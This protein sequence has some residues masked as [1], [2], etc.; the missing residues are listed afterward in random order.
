MQIDIKVEVP[1]CGSGEQF[2]QAE[3]FKSTSRGHSHVKNISPL[4]QLE[5]GRDK[6]Q[7]Y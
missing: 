1:G 2:R 7:G 4:N 6:V 5:L 3:L